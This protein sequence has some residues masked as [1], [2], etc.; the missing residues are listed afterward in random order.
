MKYYNNFKIIKSKR[1]A[2]KIKYYNFFF[3]LNIYLY[4]NIIYVLFNKI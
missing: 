3:I 1:H 4:L 2:N